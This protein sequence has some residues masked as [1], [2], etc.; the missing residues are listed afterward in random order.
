MDQRDPTPCGASVDQQRDPTPCS[1]VRGE[2]D[3]IKKEPQQQRG[4]KYKTWLEDRKKRGKKE[5]RSLKEYA[6]R[7]V[8]LTWDSTNRSQNTDPYYPPLRKDPSPETTATAPAFYAA[9]H[10]VENHHTQMEHPAVED[11]EELHDD[12]SSGSDEEHSVVGL[13]V[14]RKR[15][16]MQPLEDV[17]VITEFTTPY[18]SP[19]QHQQRSRTLSPETRK[20]RQNIPREQPQSH[21]AARF[22]VHPTIYSE[23]EYSTGDDSKNEDFLEDPPPR[24]QQELVVVTTSSSASGETWQG[25]LRR[26]GLAVESSNT[27]ASIVDPPTGH[28][29]SADEGDNNHQH[30]HLSIASS[31]FGRPDAPASVDGRAK[32]GYG[33][34]G[35][36]KMGHE[37]YPDITRSVSYN[38]GR[39]SFNKKQAMRHR[40]G[41]RQ[42]AG[43]DVAPSIDRVYSPRVDAAPSIQFSSDYSSTGGG[44]YHGKDSPLEPPVES[45]SEDAM[46]PQDPSMSGDYLHDPSISRD[47]TRS[48][49]QDYHYEGQ[50]PS[51]SLESSQSASVDSYHHG[52]SLHYEDNYHANDYHYDGRGPST[53]EEHSCADE[54]VGDASFDPLD[55]DS[56]YDEETKNHMVRERLANALSRP[57]VADDQ[58]D[59]QPNIVISRSEEVLSENSGVNDAVEEVI[60]DEKQQEEEN[61]EEH[62]QVSE[63][64]HQQQ[65]DKPQNSPFWATVRPQGVVNKPRVAYYYKPDLPSFNQQ[66]KPRGETIPGLKGLFCFVGEPYSSTASMDQSELEEKP[67]AQPEGAY[68][69]AHDI[70][71]METIEE[72]ADSSRVEGPSLPGKMESNGIAEFS[73]QTIA[74]HTI[75]DTSRIEGPSLIVESAS[76]ED[77]VFDRRISAQ[78]MAARQRS[79]MMDEE[80]SLA[81]AVSGHHEPHLCGVMVHCT[82]PRRSN[83]PAPHSD[84][85]DDSTCNSV[86]SGLDVGAPA[87]EDMGGCTNQ[88]ENVQSPASSPMSSANPV[89]KLLSNSRKGLIQ[90][91]AGLAPESACATSVGSPR[92]CRSVDSDADE[93]YDA[94]EGAASVNP[95]KTKIEGTLQRQSTMMNPESRHLNYLMSAGESGG[96][97]KKEPEKE[98]KESNQR[99]QK[100]EKFTNSTVESLS[101]NVRED[102]DDALRGVMG[103]KRSVSAKNRLAFEPQV[104]SVDSEKGDMVAEV[105]KTYE[106]F[107]SGIVTLQCR[108]RKMLAI[109]VY[110]CKVGAVIRLQAFGR[111]AAA[112]RSFR[113]VRDRLRENGGAVLFQTLFRRSV[114]LKRYKA[115]RK[116]V[117]TIQASFRRR[118]VYG[119]YVKTKKSAVVIQAHY[120]SFLAVECFQV[121]RTAT[122]I[123]QSHIRQ[124]SASM[125]TNFKEKKESSLRIQ[126][127]YRMSVA[128]KQYRSS[129]SAIKIQASYR[130]SIATKHFRRSI[131]AIKIQ[132]RYRMLVARKGFLN[133]TAA[134]KIQSQFRMLVARRNYLA[135]TAAI[136][137]QSLFHMAVATKRFESMRKSAIALQSF[138]RTQYAVRTFNIA[139]QSVLLLQKTWR[140]STKKKQYTV[141]KGAAV[142]LQSFSRPRQLSRAYAKARNATIVIQMFQRAH[143]ARHKFR[144]VLSVTNFCQTLWRAYVVRKSFIRQRDAIVAIQSYERRRQ[145]R[146]A[147][148]AA[149]IFWKI[150][151]AFS[152]STISESGAMQL[153]DSMEDDDLPAKAD[154]TQLI[155]LMG[156]SDDMSALDRNGA[157]TDVSL[158]SVGEVSAVTLEVEG[159]LPMGCPPMLV[160][161]NQAERAARPGT[162]AGT[163]EPNSLLSVDGK[164]S[165]LLSKAVRKIAP[166][167]EPVLGRSRS[168]SIDSALPNEVD[169]ADS[170]MSVR[171]DRVAKDTKDNYTAGDY[172]HY[173]GDYSTYTGARS[174]FTTPK[175]EPMEFLQ[176]GCAPVIGLVH[177]EG[178]DESFQSSFDDGK[179]RP[180]MFPQ[181]KKSPRPGRNLGGMRIEFADT[182]DEYSVDAL[183]YTPGHI[184]KGPATPKASNLKQSSE[185]LAVEMMADL[186]GIAVQTAAMAEETAKKTAVMA[187]ETAKKTVVI[188][189]ETAK[190]AFAAY[191]DDSR[192]QFSDRNH[193]SAHEHS[194]ESRDDETY[195]DNYTYTSAETDDNSVGYSHPNVA[196]EDGHVDSIL[197]NALDFVCLTPDSVKNFFPQSPRDDSDILG[198][199]SKFRESPAD[200]GV[201][202][203]S[204]LGDQS[205][206][207]ADSFSAHERP[208]LEDDDSLYRPQRPDPPRS[209]SHREKASSHFFFSEQSGRPP[210]PPSPRHASPRHS[211]PRHGFV[212]H[213]TPVTGVP[214]QDTDLQTNDELFHLLATMLIE[215]FQ[216]KLVDGRRAVVIQPE[217]KAQV[218]VLLPSQKCL[219]FIEAVQRR[220][221]ALPDLPTTPFTPL[222]EITRRCHDL[223]FDLERKNN[224]ILVATEMDNKPVEVDLPA[225]ASDTKAASEDRQAECKPQIDKAEDGRIIGAREELTAELRDAKNLLAESDNPE[226]TVFWRNHIV[227]LTQRLDSLS[228]EG[229]LSYKE[230]TATTKQQE[231]YSPPRLQ[232]AKQPLV[233]EPS[234][235]YDS[236]SMVDVISPADLPGGYHFEAEIEG[237]RFLA[238][239][240]PGGVQ[241]GE[242]FSCT[243]RELDSVAVDIPVGYWKDGLTDVCDPGCSHVSVWNSIFCPL[244]ALAQI[245]QRIQLDFL[246]RA[247]HPE[248]DE[249]YY[250]NRVMMVIVI[251]FW[252]FVNCALL[253]GCCIKLSG[254]LELTFADYSALGLINLAM[255]GFNVFVSQSTRYSLR[256]KFMIREER[257]YDLED[258]VC[259]TFCLPCVV[260]QMLRHTAN[261]DEH[262]GFCC[263]NTGLPDGVGVH[264]TPEAIKESPYIV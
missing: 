186:K 124:W 252:L 159:N 199:R 137:I 163:Q 92:E 237:R 212:H 239:V 251:L 259:S 6:S 77:E 262:E 226:T 99:Q 164:K 209:G 113:R 116:A 83:S 112:V 45:V 58:G 146:K 121:V 10:L 182:V 74:H 151:T 94:E 5:T 188:A 236:P 202:D 179:P 227:T 162:I 185:N 187:E 171:D 173:D 47:S 103:T 165:T 24:E 181:R 17:S 155:T 31:K 38:S 200:S 42:F 64:Q 105:E 25:N 147:L 230:A 26:N 27:F 110:H 245:G 166:T 247:K 122:V 63:H 133:S 244:V 144:K 149:R 191:S 119:L 193:R 198:G 56:S 66:E 178:A 114:A 120:R 206:Y 234:P 255:I 109:R 126:S 261:Y 143:I 80:N 73:H 196:T 150:E 34:D 184:P 250:S 222:Q 138:F 28:S 253:L 264:E 8:S 175:K 82:K 86:V 139:V 65:N 201:L 216:S 43:I 241:K 169:L 7:S 60:S 70:H 131:A 98:V 76:M 195:T 117:I 13:V 79:V 39:P 167:C 102:F 85:E 107:L 52:K 81:S 44:T 67:R 217:D 156:S 93:F 30:D 35:R 240:P 135:S 225:P 91:I 233:K 246:G 153:L 161:V 32:M 108:V 97:N 40:I 111:T 130:M 257:C 214:E 140:C 242:T 2:S 95:Q 1:T 19:R 36:A 9:E 59:H 87:Y 128:R 48:S 243:M 256:E 220:F 170:M 260:S 235:D 15:S 158:N 168:F 41:Q 115:T 11:E 129:T 4:R 50:G 127:I 104:H 219:A 72:N 12:C 78:R 213:R 263:S 228:G 248:N 16:D 90:T 176:K 20:H 51:I 88:L 218:E 75:E 53:E 207:R 148:R 54:Q 101:E 210:L 160:V 118:E 106:D 33:A 215:L 136:K 46:S 249:P 203:E 141:L 211:S 197:D 232:A 49:H 192:D 183:S 14:H 229:Q 145:A 194:V 254:D 134:I 204:T 37:N 69:L 142:K 189:E 84:D 177:S 258:I 223:G 21:G 3:D 100:K 172:S 224:P 62:G 123:I 29:F 89:E 125:R 96:L 180:E 23:E 55:Y 208:I 61:P 22:H 152:S 190:R 68:E 132:S 205:S 57:T 221:A 18:D 71:V 157:S 231:P 154:A 174:E 238:T